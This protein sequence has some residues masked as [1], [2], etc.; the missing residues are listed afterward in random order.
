MKRIW[1]VLKWPIYFFGGFGLVLIIVIYLFMTFSPQFGGKIS[2]EQKEAFENLDHYED[3]KFLN[4]LPINLD[5]SLK[6]MI[7]MSKEMFNPD[8]DVVPHKNIE[9]KQVNP[10]FL[11]EDSLT[12]ITWLGHSSFFINLKKQSILVDPIFSQY[13]APH[14]WFGKKRFND[15]MPF[16]IAD[17]DEVDVVIIS[18]DHYDHLDYK[19]I[20]ELKSK[21]NHFLVP[22]GVGAHLRAWDVDSS[23]ITEMD[24]WEEKVLDEIT[25]VLTPSRHASGRGLSD[26]SATL[27]GSWCFL[28]DNDKIYFSGDGGYD[29]HF[30]EIGNKYGPFDFAMIECGQYNEKWEGVHMYPEE[31]VQAGIDVKANKM[32]PIHWGAFSLAPHAWYEPVQRFQNKANELN[33]DYCLPEIGATIYLNAP[34]CSDK[35]WWEE[36]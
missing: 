9:V 7:A 28:T 13:A 26:Q 35:K 25:F 5:M 17:I 16:N 24:W 20:L 22:L 6:N 23:K 21:V 1:K 27:W 2:K 12:N 36:F 11:R 32:M 33:A 15:S 29:V 4:N 10:N 18:H 14:K 31:S 19:S 3:G 34:N 30:K 8:K